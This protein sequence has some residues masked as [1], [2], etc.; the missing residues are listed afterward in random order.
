MLVVLI[1]LKIAC[2]RKQLCVLSIDRMNLTSSLLR[3]HHPCFCVSPNLNMFILKTDKRSIVAVVLKPLIGRST[4]PII[5]GLCRCL[6]KLSEHNDLI[7]VLL[8]KIGLA[9]LS[10][11]ATI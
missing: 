11:Y 4:D 9:S 8:I 2:R 10:S 3:I 1:Y 5:L 7:A 6:N